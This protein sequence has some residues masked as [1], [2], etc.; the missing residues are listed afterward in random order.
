MKPDNKRSESLKEHY[1]KNP[2]SSKYANKREWLDSKKYYRLLSRYGLT[3][4]YYEYIADL[5]DDLCAICE[6][7][8][9]VVDHDHKTDEV[10]GLLCNNCNWGLGNFMDRPELLVR[11]AQYLS[12][13]NYLAIKN[14]EYISD[15]NGW[16]YEKCR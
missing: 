6:K 1:R 9:V 13:D 10:R 11:A 14:T 7:E 8:F 4:R 16:V 12:S 3:R 2:R 15:S 5:Q